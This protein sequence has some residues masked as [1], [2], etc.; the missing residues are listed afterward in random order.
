MGRRIPAWDTATQHKDGPDHGG[1]DTLTWRSS[2]HHQCQ[3]DKGVVEL[4]L[5]MERVESVEQD[6]A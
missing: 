2:S 1:I 4:K 3:F 6:P 5:A